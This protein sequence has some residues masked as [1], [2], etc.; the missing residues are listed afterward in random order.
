MPNY[1]DDFDIPALEQEVRMQHTAGSNE[2]FQ[3]A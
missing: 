2:L 1:Y 3:H